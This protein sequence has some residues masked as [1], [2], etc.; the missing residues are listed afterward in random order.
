MKTADWQIN[1][2]S[3]KTISDLLSEYGE[4]GA[5]CHTHSAAS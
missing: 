5:K 4:M 2:D 1:V 3:Q